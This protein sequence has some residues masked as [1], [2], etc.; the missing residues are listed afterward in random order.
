MRKLTNGQNW[1]KYYLEASVY[2]ERR[3]S[4]VYFLSYLTNGHFVGQICEKI[5][6]K[7]G[8]NSPSAN[9][10]KILPRSICV[11]RNTIFRWKLL[12]LFD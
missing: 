2:P 4:V 8:Q 10:T 7:L 12:E 6:R 1:S 11:Y 5:G 9:L 3:F